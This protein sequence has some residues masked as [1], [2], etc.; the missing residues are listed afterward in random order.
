ME[1]IKDLAWRAQMSL[2]TLERFELNGWSVVAVGFERSSAA[3]GSTPPSLFS[4]YRYR[5]LF[6]PKGGKEPVYALNLERSILGD[7]II[8]EQEGKNHRVVEHLSL[9]PSYSDFRI[10]ALERALNHFDTEKNYLQKKDE[11]KLKNLSAGADNG[12]N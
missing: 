4:S 8:G 2:G 11:K 1:A 5:L 7:W 6:F 3:G 10:R 12:G 9:L